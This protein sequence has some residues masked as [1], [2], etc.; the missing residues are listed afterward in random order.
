MDTYELERTVKVTTQFSH[1]IWKFSVSNSNTWSPTNR[2]LDTLINGTLIVYQAAYGIAGYEE[3]V[4][5]L[6]LYESHIDFSTTTLWSY[7]AP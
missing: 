7:L 2:H 5:I 4:F 6:I 1:Q 3:L